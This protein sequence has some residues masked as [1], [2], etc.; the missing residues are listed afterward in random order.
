[1]LRKCNQ[2]NHDFNVSSM[3][4]SQPLKKRISEKYGSLAIVFIVFII[5]FTILTIFPYDIPNK[6]V[7]AFLLGAISSFLTLLWVYPKKSLAF[8]FFSKINFSFLF[9]NLFAGNNCYIHKWS[10]TV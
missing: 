10:C 2:K 1:M 8:A 3:F 4:E 6:I 9:F 7:F 5:P